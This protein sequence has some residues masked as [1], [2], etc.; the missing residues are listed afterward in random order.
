MA[1]ENGVEKQSAV[2]ALP[3]HK[4]D[5]LHFLAGVA[6]ELGDVSRSEA[7]HLALPSRI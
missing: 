6:I 5:P 2:S 7:L 1:P 3:N 4:L